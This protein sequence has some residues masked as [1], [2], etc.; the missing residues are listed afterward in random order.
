MVGVPDG[1]GTRCG[2]AQVKKSATR[3]RAYLS[4]LLRAQREEQVATHAKA[5]AA[6]AQARQQAVTAVAGTQNRNTQ[7]Q[8]AE[9]GPEA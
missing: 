2:D 9:A 3:R 8:A 7:P 1:L 4:C 6:A 5:I